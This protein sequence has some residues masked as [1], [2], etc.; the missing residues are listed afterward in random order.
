MIDFHSHILP[1]IDDGSRSMEETLNLIQEAKE[2]GFTQIISTSHYMEDYCEANESERKILLNNVQKQENEIELFLGS[3][4][5]I[6]DEMVSLLQEKEASTINHSRY[7]LFE[8]PMNMKPFN[9]KE[10]VYRLIENGYVPI[11]AHPERY[12]YVQKDIGY[13]SELAQMGALFQS[14]YGSIVGWYGKDAEKTMKKLLKEDAIHFL[15]SDV[16]RTNHTYTIIPKAL[17]KLRKIISEEKLEE[18]T[19]I[20]AQKVLDNQEME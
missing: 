13:V 11:I 20:N 14:N 6:S 17:K 16:H 18:L 7:V 19:T 12:H 5:Y 3:E 9:G 2:V 4:I 10:T 15:G 8:L 1:N